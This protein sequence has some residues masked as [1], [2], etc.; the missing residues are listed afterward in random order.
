MND[1]PMRCAMTGIEIRDAGDG[2][3]DDGEW[4]S[5][6]YI[7]S[8]LTEQ[9]N[10]AGLDREIEYLDDKVDREPSPELMFRILGAQQHHEHTLDVI[11][12]DWGA[13]GEAYANEKFG[14]KLCRQKNAAG[15]DERLDN[16]L[17]EIKT[18]TP[19]KKR[20]YVRVKR[21]GNFSML[22]AVMITPDC[23][24][25]ARFLPRSELPTARDDDEYAY[26]DWSRMHRMLARHWLHGDR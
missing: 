10:G 12:P 9:E 4:I 15:H 24:V 23:K 22:L 1:S 17:V 26:V 21:A 2:V 16:E 18:I 5:W 8:R 7:N 11:S 25:E 3:W 19:H 20:P 14:V 6:A 13:I